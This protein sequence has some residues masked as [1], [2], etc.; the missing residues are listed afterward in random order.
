MSSS[1][2]AL[3]RPRCIGVAERDEQVRPGLEEAVEALPELPA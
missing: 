1:S 2:A 3:E